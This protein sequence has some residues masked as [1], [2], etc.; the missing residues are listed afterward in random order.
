[1]GK[2]INK[3]VIKAE[4]RMN[5]IFGHPKDPGVGMPTGDDGYTPDVSPS[6]TREAV[7]E[8]DFTH[9]ELEEGMEDI[10]LSAGIQG[11]FEMGDLE[12]AFE[13]GADEGEGNEGSER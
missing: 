7:M 8:G 1:M 2:M 3:L 5:K 11:F 10:A 6:D 13:D 4:K 9:A 12:G